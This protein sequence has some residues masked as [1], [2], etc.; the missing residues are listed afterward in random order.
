MRI[1]FFGIKFYFVINLVRNVLRKLNLV[2]IRLDS[3]YSWRNK[4]F[5]NFILESSFFCAFE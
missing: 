5:L 3:S 2:S 4:P 1:S